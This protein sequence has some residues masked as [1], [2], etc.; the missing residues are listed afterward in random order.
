LFL[1]LSQQ[2]LSE[3][4][5]SERN[6]SVLAATLMH[7]L[8]SPNRSLG[9]VSEDGG[10]KRLQTELLHQLLQ[11]E[12]GDTNQSTITSAPAVS[13]LLP[14]DWFYSINLSL[15]ELTKII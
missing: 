1:L 9:H 10:E 6:K 3:E 11:E 12:D 5:Q 2:L 15:W 14:L 13:G 7:Q 8:D 4:N